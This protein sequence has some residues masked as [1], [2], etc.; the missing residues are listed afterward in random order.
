[1]KKWQIYKIMA[2]KAWTSNLMHQQSR[3]YEAAVLNK[4]LW[5]LQ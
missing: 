5:R 2:K 1:M 3:I 4:F